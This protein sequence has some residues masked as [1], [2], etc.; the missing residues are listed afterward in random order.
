MNAERFERNAPIIQRLGAAGAE[1]SDLDL[2]REG[3]YTL[4]YTPFEYVNSSARLCIVGIT[5]GTTQLEEAYRAAQRLLEQGASL[6]VILRE[7]KKAA[8]FSGEMRKNLVRILRH[9]QFGEL[10]GADESTLWGTNAALLHSTSVIPHATFKGGKM[11]AGPFEEILRAPL[12]R[13][14]FE[15]DFL[16]ELR[17]LPKSTWFIG[18]GPT[19]LAALEWC[20]EYDHLEPEQLLGAFPHPSGKGGSQ[21]DYFLREKTRSDLK[22]KDPVRHRVDWLDKAHAELLDNLAK[23]RAHRSPN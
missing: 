17:C 19:P 18:L 22:P 21:I 15:Q 13:K 14:H 7:T 4:R 23:A 6:D 1:S 9:F 3:R 20:I 12:L 8:A 5:P 2:E 16:P 10:L 11:F